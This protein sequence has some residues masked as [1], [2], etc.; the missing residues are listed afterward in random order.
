MTSTPTEPSLPDR[1]P[2]PQIYIVKPEDSLSTIAYQFYGHAEDWVY[3]AQANAVRLP[4]PSLL[5]I[6]QELLLPDIKE[7]ER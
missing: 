1:G 3:I 4:N 2:L 7:G 6:G 5:T